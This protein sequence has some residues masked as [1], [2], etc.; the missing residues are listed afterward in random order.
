M[1]SSFRGAKSMIPKCSDILRRKTERKFYW[2]SEILFECLV[3]KK[4]L[5]TDKNKCAKMKI[6]D[7]NKYDC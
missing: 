2:F 4:L 7:K 6:F 1:V 5:Q 3:G